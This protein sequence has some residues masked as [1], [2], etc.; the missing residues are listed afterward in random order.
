MSDRRIRG[1]VYRMANLNTQYLRSKGYRYTN[2]IGHP[3][4]CRRALYAR[5]VDEVCCRKDNRTGINGNNWCL[6]VQNLAV[7]ESTAKA[8]VANRQVDG[9]VATCGKVHTKCFLACS[10]VYNEVSTREAV[11]NG[12][13]TITACDIWSAVPSER[14]TETLLRIWTKYR[15]ASLNTQ[16]I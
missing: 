6:V 9:I 12:G 14:I 4:G 10:T 8:L 1:H 15:I 5:G 2:L 3:V 11:V 7:S 13:I 16:R